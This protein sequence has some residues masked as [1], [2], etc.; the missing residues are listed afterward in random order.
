MRRRFLGLPVAASVLGLA[1]TMW[2][3]TAAQARTP[4]AAAP[5]SVHLTVTGPDGSVYDGDLQ[6]TGHTVT[7]AT[8]GSHKCDGTNNG[9]NPSPGATPTAALDDAAKA[10]DFPWDGTWY[11]SFEDYFVTSIDGD[12]QTAEAY[13]NISV[14][15]QATSV[16]GCQHK[17]SAGDDVAFTWTE[18]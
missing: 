2:A 10:E 12:A 16:G 5:I 18:M 8:G 13:W 7:A 15:G 1:L 4:E 17:L 11:A 14:N 9:A 3:P 6:T